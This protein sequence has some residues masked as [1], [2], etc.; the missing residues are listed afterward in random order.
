LPRGKK[1]A[2]IQYKHSISSCR[3]GRAVLFWAVS[4]EMQ[5]DKNIHINVQIPS[6]QISVTKEDIFKNCAINISKKWIKK[7]KIM[8]RAVLNNV[9]IIVIIHNVL[10]FV[11]QR[12]CKVIF[13][14]YKKVSSL[15]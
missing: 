10:F 14:I 15:C 5:D 6:E 7:R 12:Y 8:L 13:I 9:V 1:G 4:N 3:Y 11:I 2:K